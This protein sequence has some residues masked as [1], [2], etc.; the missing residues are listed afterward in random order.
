MSA[1]ILTERPRLLVILPADMIGGAETRTY[2]LL[3]GLRSFDRALLTQ[4]SIAG[5]YS[6][7]SIPIHRFDDFGGSDPYVFTCRN[8]LRYAWAVRTIARR[9]K[10]QLILA[11]MHNGTLFASMARDFFFLDVPVVGTILGN[12][13]AYFAALDRAPS[14]MERWIIRRCLRSPNGIITPSCGVRDDLV[15]N[16]GASPEKLQVIH[17]GVDLDRCRRMARED[18]SLA[19]AK[20]RPWIVSAC[21]FSAQK[22][23]P[24]LLVAFK[25]ILSSRPAKLVLV[26]GG[27]LREEVRRMASDLGILDHIVMTGFQENPFPYLVKADVFVLSSFF[28]GFGNVIVEAMALGVPVVASDCPSG[29]REIIVDGESGFLVPVGDW[30]AMADRCLSL[31]GDRERRE[32]LIQ[33]G[34][35]RADVFGVDTMVTAFEDY[36]MRTL[37]PSRRPESG[38]DQPSPKA[39]KSGKEEFPDLNRNIP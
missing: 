30:R 28:E 13:S 27:E 5:F 17:N 1:G 3:K 12:V 24:T 25:A 4:T 36:L 37:K 7:L 10:S 32:S 35:R 26:G 23:F 8:I 9:K 29:P 39:Q 22:D 2:N 19:I 21:R 14:F 34:L 18:A 31:L 11:L 20:D 33:A 38:P 15:E 16:H 6:G